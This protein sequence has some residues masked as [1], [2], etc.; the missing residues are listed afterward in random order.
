MV[1]GG[2]K[3]EVAAVDSIV[4]DEGVVEVDVTIEFCSFVGKQVS[5]WSLLLVTVMSGL[6]LER[7]SPLLEATGCTSRTT[8]VPSVI[9]IPQDCCVELFEVGR[10]RSRTLS[11]GINTRISGG[12]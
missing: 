9:L 10:S 2:G 11:P 5:P 4:V 7:S 8:C 1:I 6:V 12:S 3:V